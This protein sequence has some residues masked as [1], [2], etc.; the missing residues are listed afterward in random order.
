M[1]FESGD[2]SRVPPASPIR[3]ITHDPNARHRQGQPGSRDP[4]PH[5]KPEE[6]APQDVVEVSGA[7]QKVESALPAPVDAAPPSAAPARHLDINV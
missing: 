2:L 4:S 3:R 5:D 1:S 6:E 7:Y